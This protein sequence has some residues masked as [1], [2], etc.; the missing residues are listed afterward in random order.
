MAAERDELS[1]HEELARAVNEAYA[2]A[3]L[4]EA[5]VAQAAAEPTESAPEEPTSDEAEASVEVE[6]EAA[7]AVSATELAQVSDDLARARADLY[8]LQQ[9]YNAFVRRTRGELAA[10]R[11]AGAAAV[12]EALIPV[13]DDLHLARAHGD[14]HGPFAAIADKL[15]ATLASQHGFARFGEAGEAFDPTQHEALVAMPHAEVEQDTVH[16][17]LQPGYRAGERVL[18]PARVAVHTPTE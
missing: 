1:G 9:E 14:L 8:N 11:V 6:G 13:F 12:I 3:G 7:A 17:V 18:R 2:E 4:S 10:A 15:E 16:E 5:E